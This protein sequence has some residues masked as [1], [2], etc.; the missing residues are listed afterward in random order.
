[1]NGDLDAPSRLL[2]SLLDRA[3]LGVGYFDSG[4]RLVYGN[5]T[6]LAAAEAAGWSAAEPWEDLLETARQVLDDP[7]RVRE[8]GLAPKAGRAV[9]SG[10]QLAQV[11]SVLDSDAAAGAGVVL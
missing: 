11:Y 3:P 5:S 8:V 6:F 4:L 1:M 2:A 10:T 7:G 9:E